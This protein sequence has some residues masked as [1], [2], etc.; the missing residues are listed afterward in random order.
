M[1]WHGGSSYQLPEC[2]VPNLRNRRNGRTVHQDIITGIVSKTKA[3]AA[4]EIGTN[5]DVEN[6]LDMEQ[7]VATSEA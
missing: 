2:R 4:K 7:L 6:S 5:G 1:E 3:N